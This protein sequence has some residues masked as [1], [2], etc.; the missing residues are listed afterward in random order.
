MTK[1]EYGAFCEMYGKTLRNLVLENLLVYQSLD[2]SVGDLAED[3]GI[4]RPKAYQEVYK[5]ENQSLIVK[6]RIMSGTQL[7]KLNN[8]NI[9]VKKLKKDFNYCLKLVIDKHLGKGQSKTSKHSRASDKAKIHA[10]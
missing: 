3:I 8:D 5:L 7:W 6:S 10:L 4:S 2:F 1:L 9:I